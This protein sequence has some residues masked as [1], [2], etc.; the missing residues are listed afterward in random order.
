MQSLLP[1]NILGP[2]VGL[3]R[4]CPQAISPNGGLCFPQDICLLDKIG[5]IPTMPS[6][7]FHSPAFLTQ[8]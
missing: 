3:R 7:L 6:S 5:Q 4:G 8:V 1:P 2:G